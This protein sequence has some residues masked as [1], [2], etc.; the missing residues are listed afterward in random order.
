MSH[1]GHHGGRGR[2]APH[3]TEPVVHITHSVLTAQSTQQGQAARPRGTRGVPVPM[4]RTLM[5][6]SIST[7]RRLASASTSTWQMEH[8][9]RW[10][11][12]GPPPNLRGAEEDGGW[13]GHKP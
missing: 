1:T 6:V 2:C 8:T 13:R 3:F 7:F 12:A 9:Y 4:P 10:F 11:T 5:K